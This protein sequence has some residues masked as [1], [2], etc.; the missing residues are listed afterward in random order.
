MEG[1]QSL[2]NLRELYLSHNGIEVIEGL[3]NN[4]RHPLVRGSVGTGQKTP[5]LGG[6]VLETFPG[7][8]TGLRL[9]ANMCTKHPPF[10]LSP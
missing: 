8:K 2:V 7:L 6:F 1:L 10:S 4:V 9:P 5:C 3:E